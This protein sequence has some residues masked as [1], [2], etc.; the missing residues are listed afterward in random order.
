MVKKFVLHPAIT[1]VVKVGE[2]LVLHGAP[3]LVKFADPDGRLLPLFS[4]PDGFELESLAAIA[5]SPGEEEDL[6]AMVNVLRER[7]LIIEARASRERAGGDEYLNWIDLLAGSTQS[8]YR[9]FALPTG[10]KA[11]DGYCVDVVGQGRLREVLA[12]LL[13]NSGIHVNAGTSIPAAAGSLTVI[14]GD[15]TTSKDALRRMNREVVRLGRNALYIDI[16]L[17]LISV[18][19]LYVPK[20]S[21]CYDCLFTRLRSNAAV[22]SESGQ[23]GAWVKPAGEAGMLATAVGASLAANAIVQLAHG[24]RHMVPAGTLIEFDLATHSASH[25]RVV[26]APRCATCASNMANYTGTSH[27]RVTELNAGGSSGTRIG[28]G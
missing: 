6:A 28:I 4:S 19:P 10:T 26:R 17:P 3:D 24:L 15:G 11:V 12:E 1:R 21:A 27:F 7:G 16:S 13:M 14:C 9:E 5:L 20:S 25:T 2:E 18:G 22:A 23:R 8:H